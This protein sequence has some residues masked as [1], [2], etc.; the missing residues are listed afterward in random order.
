MAARN[1]EYRSIYYI[2]GCRTSG[3]SL[4]NLERPNTKVQHSL[5]GAVKASKSCVAALPLELPPDSSVL[6]SYVAD[7]RLPKIKQFFP[8]MELETL[9]AGHWLHAER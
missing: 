2:M 5:F 1:S 6:I 4:M 7:S 8:R 3:T 9:D